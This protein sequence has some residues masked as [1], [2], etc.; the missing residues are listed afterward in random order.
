M[1]ENYEDYKNNLSE[2]VEASVEGAQLLR[3]FYRNV[4]VSCLVILVPSLLHF[5]MADNILG[6]I[7]IV[8]LMSGINLVF[9]I[10]FFEMNQRLSMG[11][12]VAQIEVV[13]KKHY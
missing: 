7:F 1:N 9:W 6:S 4:I 11:T 12:L 8:L 2:M 10:I 5:F 3:K 13:A